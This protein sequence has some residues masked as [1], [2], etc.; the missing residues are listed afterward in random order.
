MLIFAKSNDILGKE[1]N[2]SICIVIG[3]L[4]KQNGTYTPSKQ[5]KNTKN[6]LF[7]FASL[8]SVIEVVIYR[9]LVS[10]HVCISLRL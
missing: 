9:A 3:I 2:N 7:I 10:L 6:V 5:A 4:E 1:S 8:F